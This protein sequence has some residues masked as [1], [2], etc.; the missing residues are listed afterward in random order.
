MKISKLNY[1]EKFKLIN[2]LTTHKILCRSKL[3]IDNIYFGNEIEFIDDEKRVLKDRM[4]FQE[5]EEY[6]KKYNDLMNDYFNTNTVN[7][8]SY[9]GC[10]YNH[11]WTINTEE[12]CSGELSSPIFTNTEES[13]KE[14]YDIYTMLKNNN[15]GINENC[16]G[17]LSI[18]GDI[19]EGKLENVISFLKLY[20]LYEPELIGISKGDL[21]TLRKK[22]FDY[23]PPISHRILPLLASGDYPKVGG[24]KEL[25]KF[26]D[27]VPTY[28][29][30]E[31]SLT[32]KHNAINFEVLKLSGGDKNRIEL[33]YPNGTLN[34]IIFQNNV[35]IISRLCLTAVNKKSE[36]DKLF[37]KYKVVELMR[38]KK[39]Q[40]KKINNLFMK[41]I[42]K[43]KDKE[44]DKIIS[45]ADFIF[46]NDI[47][48]MNLI[49]QA[50]MCS[51]DYKFYAKTK[52]F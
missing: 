13:F 9:H 19:F 17:Q 21:K 18:G 14:I 51:G 31:R 41:P 22:I 45:L 33:R 32:Y 29:I 48:K 27:S 2:S 16:S 5:R 36:V 3:D 15:Y 4:I 10:Y 42:F 7:F 25:E 50:M 12:Y 20:S 24:D 44:M 35:N 38:C 39:Y 40:Q 37:N 23:A 49:K 28:H 34:P 43:I 6:L 52:D 30:F 47:D 11:N 1:S 46:D 26:L 8:N